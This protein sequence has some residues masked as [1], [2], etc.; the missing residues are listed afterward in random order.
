MRSQHEAALARWLR[1]HHGVITADEAVRLGITYGALRE[2]VGKGRLRRIYQ[3][4][5][6]ETPSRTIPALAASAAALAAAGHTAALSH[7]SGAWVW[8][9]LQQP[10]VKVDLLVPAGSRSRLAG[11]VIH[12]TH[13][14]FVVLTRQD[15]R[16]TDP[17]RTMIDVAATTPGHLASVVD[18][19]L[20][21]GLVHIGQLQA[22]T[23]PGLEH[24][25]RGVAV[26][27]AH[28][29]ERG[30]LGAPQPSVL[31][32]L[33]MRQV[34]R[35]HHLPAPQTEVTAGWFG[36]YRIDFAYPR[37]MLAIEVDGY[38]WHSSQAHMEADN[39]RRNHLKTLGWHVL[40]YTWVQVTRSSD[41]TAAE[42]RANYR[43]L[44]AA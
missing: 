1:R 4:V 34:F 36:Q 40:V 26:L 44:A 32:S 31:E 30:H 38:V 13:T 6:A 3:G 23:G 14:P 16:V 37:L 27:R 35:R 24:R 9:L 29:H 22:A 42:I 21:N 15:L 10:P 19:G 17:V 11:A 43:R 28:L 5:Y 20:A 41:A 7:R 39:A 12:R 25:P 8:G 33:M 2:L 18:R